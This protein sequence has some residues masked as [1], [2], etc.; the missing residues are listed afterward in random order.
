MPPHT[1]LELSNPAG[2][3]PVNLLR[4]ALTRTPSPTSL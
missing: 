1:W 2:L 4:K 3:E